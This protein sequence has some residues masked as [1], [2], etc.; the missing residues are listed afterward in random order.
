[1]SSGRDWATAS[2]KR[3]HGM[4]PRK[5]FD[6]RTVEPPAKKARSASD[7][8]LV[9]EQVIGAQ[10]KSQALNEFLG[11]CCGGTH[12]WGHSNGCND[13]RGGKYWKCNNDCRRPLK[14]LAPEEQEKRRARCVHCLA[15]P[16]EAE[17]MS[18]ADAREMAETLLEAA[19]MD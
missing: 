18:K 8:A 7:N 6:V 3:L 9:K 19:A 1:M 4:V 13:G 16:L 11:P 17:G 10:S 5:E 12:F 15:L 14:Y 2:G